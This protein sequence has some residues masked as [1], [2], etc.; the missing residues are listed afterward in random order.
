[1][2][3]LSILLSFFLFF[4]CAAEA[5]IL[6]KAKDLMGGGATFSKEEAA[7]ALKEA[8]ERR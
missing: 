4:G 3:K 1:M 7:N 5:Q 8:L 2:K 6:K